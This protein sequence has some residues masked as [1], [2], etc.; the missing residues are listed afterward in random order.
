MF[1]LIGV[2]LQLE[3]I[4]LYTTE[5]NIL[6]LKL[7]LFQL[8]QFCKLLSE[9]KKKGLQSSQN[10]ANFEYNLRMVNFGVGN[11]RTFF[12]LIGLQDVLF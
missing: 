4:A 8:L 11:I 9:L 2:L 5:F 7:R 6:G 3:D 12:G 1:W 10:G